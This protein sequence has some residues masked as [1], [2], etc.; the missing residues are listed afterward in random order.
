[1]TSVRPTASTY[2]VHTSVKKAPHRRGHGPAARGLMLVDKEVMPA[3]NVLG[4]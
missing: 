3:S 1:M 4:G 2:S